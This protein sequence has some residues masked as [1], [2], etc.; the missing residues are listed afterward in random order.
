MF[1]PAWRCA[2]HTHSR[3]HCAIYPCGSPNLAESEPFRGFRMFCSVLCVSLIACLAPVG[4]ANVSSPPL[5]APRGVS[6]EG[7]AVNLVFSER[8]IFSTCS[9]ELI[10]KSSRRALNLAPSATWLLVL[11]SLWP[12][13][14]GHQAQSHWPRGLVG[15]SRISFRAWQAH[16]YKMA[17]SIAHCTGHKRR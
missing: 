16:L 17:S 5:L 13:S 2:D 6:R 1:S 10:S 7:A 8:F 4:G 12:R 9:S 11:S 15:V 3:L 14:T